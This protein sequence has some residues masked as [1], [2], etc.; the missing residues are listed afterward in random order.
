MH[1]KVFKILTSDYTHAKPTRQVDQAPQYAP[2][3]TLATS[4]NAVNPNLLSI[5]QIVNSNL[6]NFNSRANDATHDHGPPVLGP[7]HQ[8]IYWYQ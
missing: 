1:Q 8:G 5:L 2:T 7:P 4:N 3:D 6:S